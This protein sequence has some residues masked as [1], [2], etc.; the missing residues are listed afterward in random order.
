MIAEKMVPLC[1]SDQTSSA[2]KIW[3]QTKHPLTGVEECQARDLSVESLSKGLLHH[4]SLVS[5]PPFLRQDV[6]VTVLGL[7]LVVSLLS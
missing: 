5:W 4:L 3:P 2:Q 1:K 7:V 6:P